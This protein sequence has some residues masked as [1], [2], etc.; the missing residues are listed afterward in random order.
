MRLLKNRKG[1]STLEM[2]M[3]WAVVIVALVYMMSLFTRHEK[4]YIMNQ[5]KGVSGEPWGD[6]ALYTSNSNSNSN[7]TTNATSA[8]TNS[9]SGSNST[10]TLPP[11][12]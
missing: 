6:G 5:A 9:N 1:Q 2:A 7:S 10:L 8:T 3:L 11:V 4:G 12:N